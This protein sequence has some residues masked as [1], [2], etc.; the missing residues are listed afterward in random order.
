MA[1]GSEAQTGGSS[2]QKTLAALFKKSKAKKTPKRKTP[3]RTPKRKMSKRSCNKSMRRTK[4]VKTSRKN[5]GK[6]M[7][8]GMAPMTEAYN[9]VNGDFDYLPEGKDFGGRQPFWGPSTR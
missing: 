9:G 5:K 1:K 8:G 4:K 7:K 6:V 2:I 3:K